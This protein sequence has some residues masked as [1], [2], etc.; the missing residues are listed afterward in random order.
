MIIMYSDYN[1]DHAGDRLEDDGLNM[2]RAALF[3]AG[4]DSA[5]VEK[6]SLIIDQSANAYESQLGVA[7]PRLEQNYKDAIE[8][9]APYQEELSLMLGEAGIT[10]INTLKKPPKKGHYPFI[11]TKVYNIA[12][13]GHVVACINRQI[14][15]LEAKTYTNNITGYGASRPGSPFTTGAAAMSSLR[16][17]RK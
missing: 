8:A 1:P 14:T 17:K 10:L 15:D 9:T 6:Y 5:W 3:L 11:Q 7:S 12:G 2:L 4:Q 16:R 13:D